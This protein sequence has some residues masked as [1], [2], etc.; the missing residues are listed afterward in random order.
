MVGGIFKVENKVFQDNMLVDQLKKDGDFRFLMSGRC[1]ISQCLRDNLVKGGVKRAYVPV[2]TCETV[3]APFEQLGFELSF[4]DVDRKL[5]PIFDRDLLKSSPIVL[6]TGYYGF[7]TYSESDVQTVKR[8]GH[9]VMQDITHTLLN[10]EPYSPSAD[11]I[12]GSFRKWIGVASGGIAIKKNGPFTA[13]PI[14][15]H[16]KHLLLRRQAL[17]MASENQ[18]LDATDQVFWNGELLLR[19]IFENQESDRESIQVITGFN[20]PNVVK[21][22][23]ENFSYLT[24]KLKTLKDIELVFPELVPGVTPSHLSIYS[25]YRDELK[26]FL[27]ENEIKTTVYW[28]TGPSIPKN[29]TF[30]AE[31][32]FSNILSL[33]IDQRYSFPEMDIIFEKIAEFFQTKKLITP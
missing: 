7:L 23:R 11:Y 29:Q 27:R 31:Y 25:K 14:P 21:K 10:D 9:C 16:E 32:I 24:S 12:A 18:S 30:Q 28:P 13:N 2:Y 17:Q 3:L 19:E 22:R 20:T 26:I 8:N 4:Y 1:A 15:Q 5:K 6:F 33:P